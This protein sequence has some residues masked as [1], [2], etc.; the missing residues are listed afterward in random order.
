M[1][2]LC[3]LCSRNFTL[4]LY[5]CIKAT[6]TLLQGTILLET[7]HVA[8]QITMEEL[9]VIDKLPHYC[10]VCAYHEWNLDGLVE[11]IWD[12]IDVLRIYT[13]PKVRNYDVL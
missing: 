8:V 3:L 13:K 7:L 12:Y 2:N 5:C 4:C 9:N 11:M 6:V 1:Q 10:P